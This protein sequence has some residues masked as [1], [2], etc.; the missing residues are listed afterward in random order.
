MVTQSE[1]NG[2]ISI[3]NLGWAL[4]GFL[5]VSYILCILLGFLVPD[6]G[7]HKPWTQFLPGF[8]WLTLPG[9]LIGLVEVIVYGWYVAIVFGLLY[10]FVLRRRS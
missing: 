7:L 1:R 4:S 6:G 9:F 2:S 10:N 8:V 3:V 5:V